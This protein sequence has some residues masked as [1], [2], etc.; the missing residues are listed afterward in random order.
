MEIE[1]KFLIKKMP[2]K[3][4][5]YEKKEIEQGYL[6]ANPV[7]RIRKSSEEY[8][9]TYKSR[10]NMIEKETDIALTCEEVELPLSEEAY[11][12]LRNKTD[13]HLITKTR[14][15][16]P[17]EGGLTAELDEFHGCLEGL[18]FVEV[19]FPDEAAAA[20]FASPDWFGE[21]V[22]FDKR[23]KNNYLAEINTLTEF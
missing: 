17:L 15:L 2:E 7:V 12:H 16:I 14:Y 1:R 5:Q 13:G 22:S 3:L 11:L 8:Y 20:Q 19:E 21:D 18:I 10:L 23:Y 9:L 4:N 6:C